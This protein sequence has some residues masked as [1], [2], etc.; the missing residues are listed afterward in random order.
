MSQ[1]REYLTTKDL[2]LCYELVAIQ[3]DM[4]DGC[5]PDFINNLEDLRVK[6]KRILEGYSV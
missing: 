2:Q 3:T 4:P 1:S 6:L 5:A